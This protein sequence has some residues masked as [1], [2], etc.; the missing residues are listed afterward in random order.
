MGRVAAVL[1]RFQEK[2]RGWGL[3]LAGLGGIGAGGGL[4]LVIWAPEIRSF[5]VATLAVGAS[6][7]VLSVLASLSYVAG[8]ITGR[9]GRLSWVSVASVASAAAIVATLNVIASATDAS[10]D[11][12]ATRQFEIS[13]QTAQV[14][15]VLAEDVQVTGFIVTSD[16]GDLRFEAAAEGYLRQFARL[17]GGRLNYRFVDPQL[18][19]SVALELGVTGSPVLLF[20]SSATGLRA[21]VGSRGISEQQLLTAVLTVTRTRQHKVYVLQGHGERGINDLRASGPGLGLAAAGLRA[22]G[23]AVEALDLSVSNAVPDDASLLIIA[24]P[25]APLSPDEER[26]IA[27]WLADGGRGLFMLEPSGGV[28]RSMRGLLGAWGL[29]TVEGTVVD[30]ERSTA[31]DARTLVAQRDQHLGQTS[32]TEGRAIVEPLGP[33]LYPGA[34]AFR[35]TQDIAS[36]IERGESVP[37]R[38]GPLVTSSAASWVSTGAGV[39]FVEGRDTPGPHSVHVLVQASS[40]VADGL[41]EEFEPEAVRTT[42]AVLGDVDFA[43]NRHFND[44]DNG[45]FFLNTVNWLLRDAA[46]ISVRPKQEVFR[47]LVLTAPEF[48]FVRYVSWFLIPAALAAAGLVAWWRRR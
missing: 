1:R 3:L 30:P 6:L 12:T 47:P 25:D 46:L 14:L 28:R 8:A 44:L 48:N 9:R 4:L 2:L 11:L 26:V 43:S 32:I 31:G 23:Y 18:E 40:S 15:G 21:S 42:L 22:D 37:V 36:R 24:A 39:E 45:N 17:S 41:T 38:F 33:T 16:E 34:T 19:P 7:L 10:W 35:V 27:R 20:S 29:E 5:A 13:P